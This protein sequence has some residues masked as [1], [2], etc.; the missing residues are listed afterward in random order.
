[1]RFRIRWW[2]IRW[3]TFTL[4]GALLGV[5]LSSIMTYAF[6]QMVWGFDARILGTVVFALYGAALGTVIGFVYMIIARIVRRRVK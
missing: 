6:R 3:W 1:M 4:G 2:G 5:G